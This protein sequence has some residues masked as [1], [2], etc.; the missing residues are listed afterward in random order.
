MMALAFFL[1][2]CLFVC[3][4]FMKRRVC[5]LSLSPSSNKLTGHQVEEEE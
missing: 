1:S 5:D 3:S 2:V 4:F